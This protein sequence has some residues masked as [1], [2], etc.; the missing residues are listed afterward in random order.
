LGDQP[1]GAGAAKADRRIYVLWAVGLALLLVLGVF[2]WT[3]VTPFLQVRGL[4]C[5]QRKDPDP[6][7]FLQKAGELGP[8]E[9]A[10]WKIRLYLRAPDFLAPKKGQ[11]ASLLFALNV[12]GIRE[13]DRMLRHPDPHVRWHAVD[14][15]GSCDLYRGETDPI[16]RHISSTD[17]DEAIRVI[18]G[19][20][21]SRIWHTRTRPVPEALY[22]PE[23]VRELERIREA[24]KSER[25]Q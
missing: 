17:P 2:C 22:R 19:L 13:I 23:V 3:V 12:A 16:L 21:L 1:A 11:A 9:R 6:D 24:Q 4:A 18:A 20:L 15:L 7:A 8:P 14:A 10:V 5:S 25:G